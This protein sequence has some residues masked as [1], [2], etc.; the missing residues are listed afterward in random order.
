ML[1]QLKRIMAILCIYSPLSA[2][3]KAPLLVELSQLTW[4]NRVVIVT[5]PPS[6]EDTIAVFKQHKAQIDDRD[7][8]WFVDAHTELHSNYDGEI[9]D[10]FATALRDM[11][12]DGDYDVVLVGK[13]GGVKLQSVTLNLDRLFSRIDRM[14]M[15]IREMNTQERSLTQ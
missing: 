12:R 2:A 8:V 7:I 3:D 13:D 11:A 5:E 6:A 9:S 4:A 10:E 15:R 1:D 14:P